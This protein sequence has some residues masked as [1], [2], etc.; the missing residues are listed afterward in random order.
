MTQAQLLYGSSVYALPARTLVVLPA[1]WPQVRTED[2]EQLQK[3]LAYYRVPM[4][5]AWVIHRERVTAADLS[6]PGV[7]RAVLFGV[8]SDIPFATVTRAANLPVV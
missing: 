3:L 7:S 5:Q 1:A 4:G 6:V 2:K 8:D